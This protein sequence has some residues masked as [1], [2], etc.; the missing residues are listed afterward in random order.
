MSVFIPL[1]P[2]LNTPSYWP[3]PKT[4]C[5]ILLKIFTSLG[6]KTE[7]LHMASKLAS[8]LQVLTPTVSDF[9]CPFLPL[10]LRLRAF[11]PTVLLYSPLPFSCGSPLLPCA[12]SRSPSASSNGTPY[13]PPLPLSTYHT[14]CIIE[15]A[16]LCNTLKS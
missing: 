15:D 7:V 2:S 13:P 10:S 14:R 12:L 1:W 4:G 5:S 3:L 11:W 6:I 8:S 9:L 16:S